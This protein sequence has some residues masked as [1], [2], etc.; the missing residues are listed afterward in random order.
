MYCFILLLRI[1]PER[2]IGVD[3]CMPTYEIDLNGKL[4]EIHCRILLCACVSN[5]R[6]CMPTLGIYIWGRKGSIIVHAGHLINHISQFPIPRNLTRGFLHHLSPL[7][8]LPLG[9]FPVSNISQPYPTLPRNHLLL[10]SPVSLLPTTSTLPLLFPKLMF[11][12]LQL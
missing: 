9:L 11:A 4:N 10:L 1:L 5:C 2:H 12:N 8:A 6:L 7:H 3:C